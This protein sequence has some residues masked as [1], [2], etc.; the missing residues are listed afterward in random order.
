MPKK[1]ARAAKRSPKKR[2]AP[3]R[4]KAKVSKKGVVSERAPRAPKPVITPEAITD[5]VRKGRQRGF[6]T[7]SEERL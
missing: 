1:V 2:P 5:L 4:H 6:L 3:K 7:R